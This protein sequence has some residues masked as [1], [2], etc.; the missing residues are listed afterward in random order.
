MVIYGWKNICQQF[1]NQTLSTYN[2][3]FRVAS[4]LD[5]VMMILQDSIL[6][7]VELNFI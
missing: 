2:Y 7:H 4:Y 6:Q 1:Y 3:L 5:I